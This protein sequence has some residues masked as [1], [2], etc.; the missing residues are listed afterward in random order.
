MVAP[1]QDRTGWSAPASLTWPREVVPNATVIAA[2]A[3]AGES[4]G[5]A[6]TSRATAGTRKATVCSAF[7]TEVT[8]TP[9]ETSESA[10]SPAALLPVAMTSQGRKERKLEE[11]RSNPRACKTSEDMDVSCMCRGYARVRTRR[12]CLRYNVGMR[13][14]D[15]RMPQRIGSQR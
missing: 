10:S 2:T 15:W 8:S 12:P 11:R 4:P 7:R 13:S 14:S 1:R 9:R 6:S 3:C 5:W